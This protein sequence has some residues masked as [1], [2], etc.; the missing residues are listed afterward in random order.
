MHITDDDPND[1]DMWVEKNIDIHGERVRRLCCRAIRILT[2]LVAACK[3]YSN[4]RK[5]QVDLPCTGYQRRSHP[6]TDDDHGDET[7]ARR[8]DVAAPL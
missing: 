8:M 2:P 4:G 7:A 3:G 5:S 6:P 1:D